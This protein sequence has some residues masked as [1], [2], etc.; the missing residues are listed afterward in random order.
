MKQSGL[1]HFPLGQPVPAKDHAV[2]VSLP[3]VQDL[4]GYEEK[5]SRTLSAMRSG[6]P[7]F[8][9][10][11]RIQDLI[12]HFNQG[13][14][15]PSLETFL[16]SNQADCDFFQSLY[17][18]EPAAQ[19]NQDGLIRLGFPTGSKEAEYCRLFQQHTGSSISSR[20]AEDLLYQKGKI[21]QREFISVPASPASEQITRIIAKA[22]GPSIEPADVFLA[23]SG[24]NAFYSLFRA[25][26]E[27]A[28][29]NQKKIWV[30]LGWL[31]LD[32]IK[33]MQLLIKEDENECVIALNRLGEIDRLEEIFRTQGDQIAGIVTE[34]PTN[35][36]LESFDLVRVKELCDLYD[37]LLVVDPTMASPKNAKVSSFADV[38]VNSLTKYANWEGDVM[39]GSLVFPQHS[40]RGRKLM[41]LT[42]GYISE[43]FQRDLHRMAEQIPFYESFIQ[44]TN[45]STLQVAQYLENHPNVKTVHWAY[46]EKCSQN[47]EKVAGSNNP[48]CVL[49]IELNIPF[50]TFYNSLE[51]LKSPSFGTEFTL[52]CPYVYLAHYSMMQTKAGQEELK[53]AGISPYLLRLSVGLEPVE[54]II[55]VLGQSLDRDY[56]KS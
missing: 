27:Q 37:C 43:P 6:Y 56:S 52:C 13:E 47:Y 46:Q 30:R 5:D 45:A 29:L 16:F 44:Q 24:A 21:A 39:M 1:S 18:L 49:S 42:R 40:A 48:G 11:Y 10:N 33:V 7:R 34:F 15:D 31:Y 4:I 28:R 38:V 8:V 3:T 23:N 51:M 36:L 41:P 53:Q 32:T 26:T 55:S 17:Q 54:K 2:C 9:R 19:D 20:F 12:Q 14:A 35:P 25:A 22:H 50:E